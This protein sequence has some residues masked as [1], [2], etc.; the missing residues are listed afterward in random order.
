MKGAE[1]TRQDLTISRVILFGTPLVWI[2]LAFIH[3]HEPEE[4]NRWLFV[5]FA[6]LALA[7]FLA[8]AAWMLFDGIHSKA[9]IV[10]RIALVA[11][12]AF[13]SAYD[14]AAG[15]ATGLLSRYADGLDG[16]EK[17]A[18]NAAIDYLFNDGLLPGGAAILGAVTT[19]AWPLAVIA[20]ALALHKSGAR[21]ALVAA[22]ALSALFAF[23]A[24]YP[25]GIGLA[26][27]LVA[28]GLWVRERTPEGALSSTP[29]QTA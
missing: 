17:T 2:V 4:F 11:W 15:I 26:S 19:V 29:A 16:D 25:A 21:P 20:G 18:V 9:A 12:L 5:H 3:P 14:S 24:G 13:F 23:H 6:Q 22:L 28:A 8:F 7:P 10:S 1:M 27:F